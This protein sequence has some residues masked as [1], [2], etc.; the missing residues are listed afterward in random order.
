MKK[1]IAL[2]V[3][4]AIVFAALT[5]FYSHGESQLA[6]GH[7]NVLQLFLAAKQAETKLEKD[8]LKS[9]SFLL[10]T[11]DSI[12]DDIESVEKVCLTLKSAELGIYQRQE[13]SFD[14]AIDAYCEA[15]DRKIRDVEVFKSRNAILRNS[16]YYLQKLALEDINSK[17]SAT[18]ARAVPRMQLVRASLAYAL[19]PSAEAKEFFLLAYSRAQKRVANGQGGE[20][21]ASALLHAAKIAET[22]PDLDRLTESIFAS[23]SSQLLERV[24]QSYFQQYSKLDDLAALYRR[25]LFGVCSVFLLFIIYNITRLWRSAIALTAANSDLEHRVEQRTKELS[26]SKEMIIQQ[27]QALISSAKMSS[28]GEMA[29]GIAHEINTPLGVITMRV[30]QLEECIADGSAKPDEVTETLEVVRTTAER[31]AKIVSGLRFFARD[32]R[33][34]PTRPTAVRTIIEETLNLCRE[35]FGNHGV[36]LEVSEIGADLKIDCRSVEISQVL[37]NLLNNAFDAVADLNERWVRIAVA[38]RGSLVEIRVVD[39]G[40]GI[41]KEICDKV[42]QPFFTTKPVGK[43]TGLG[44]SICRGV[45]ES[46][47]GKFAIDTEAANTCFVILLPKKSSGATSIAEGLAS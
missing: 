2:S 16:L 43:G 32:G 30:E 37:L 15:I 19:F 38:D 23:E 3:V 39:S 46:H 29:G 9:R 34:G 11:Y 6:A 17:P 10:L 1:Y 25:M 5:Y 21:E 35:K 45:I 8:L 18:V 44:L 12:V 4:G 36:Q 42:M 7:Q 24:R 33:L 40:S 28:L 27:Q 22:K 31:I 14:S 41:P 26:E 13:V 20:G 47:H